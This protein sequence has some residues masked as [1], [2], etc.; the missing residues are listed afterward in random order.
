MRVLQE[1]PR[2][3]LG[4][5]LENTY[6]KTMQNCHWQVT[7][8]IYWLLKILCNKF[9]YK[10][11]QKFIKTFCLKGWL[12]P[13][14]HPS[15]NLAVSGDVCLN[16]NWME[17]GL[18]YQKSLKLTPSR[19]G[20]SGSI[21]VSTFFYVYSRSLV[22]GKPLRLPNSDTMWQK[23]FLYCISICPGFFELADYLYAIIG[24]RGQRYTYRVLQTIQMK[25]ILLCVWAE[26]AVLGSTK[27]AL[28]FKYET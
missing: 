20:A 16:W 19:Q 26:L 11:G 1:A 21:L 24:G 28:K 15:A 7:N 22:Y 23:T 12:Q 9:H 2:K 5:F 18:G 13:R 17:D 6:N 27:T 4:G 8:Y 25:L 10:T 14:L 3:A